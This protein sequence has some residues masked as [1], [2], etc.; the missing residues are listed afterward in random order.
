MPVIPATQKA[1]AG[2]L[3]NLGGAGCNEPRSCH[4]TAAWAAEQNP[5]ERKKEERK[6]KKEK[7]KKERKK[8][9]KERLERRKERKSNTKYAL[10]I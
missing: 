5:V 3:S 1:E 9:K 7:R 10:H 8:E 2:D 6:K 4:C